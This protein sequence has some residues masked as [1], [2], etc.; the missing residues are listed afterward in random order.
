[1]LNVK[2]AEIEP[3]EICSI[4][5]PTENSSI[6]FRLT[7]NCY[8]NKCGFC[9][10]YKSGAKFSKRSIEEVELDIKK[11]KVIDDLLY[12]TGI[13]GNS[14]FYNQSS[15]YSLIAEVKQARLEAGIIASMQESSNN[16]ENSPDLDERMRWFLSWFKDKPTIEDSFTHVYSWRAGGG[17]TCF[18]GDADS[19][20]LKPDFISRA[21][22]L[23]KKT[24]PSIDRITIYGRTKSA[25]Q[26]RSLRDLK[27]Y[28]AAGINRVHFGLESGSDRVLE[29]I[30]KGETSEDH[31]NGALRVKE[32]G[33]SCS[34][35]V[36]PGVGGKALSEDNSRETARVL[37][38]IA[39]DFVRLRTLEIFPGTGLDILRKNRS[40]IE[41][42]EEEVVREIRTIISETE[43]ET[44]IVSD[45]ATNLL[46]VNGRLPHDRDR[47]LQIIDSYLD[48]TEREK[49]EFSLRSRIESFMG[50]Y[51]GLSDDI[52]S[53]L[54][55]Y[56]RS[57]M[58][59]I[60]NADD[61]DIT[62]ITTAIKSKLMP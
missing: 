9:P 47:M 31:I 24:F 46:N 60:E 10:V 23:A 48:L 12:D 44:E 57:G 62:D 32:A 29:L 53:M 54:E 39:P 56:I 14:T 33:I 58:L 7:R 55:P 28:A 49:I 17:R 52:Y 20:I 15:L 38:R 22:S 34:V 59:Y 40:F 5:P 37:S 26:V 61:E 25:A 13:T 41:A 36:M 35:Y 8:W 11:A 4:R 50:Q 3:F 42:S 19:L 43:C 30:N 16:L 27:L 21:A 18:F 51:G 1:M 45:S 2:Y 6:T